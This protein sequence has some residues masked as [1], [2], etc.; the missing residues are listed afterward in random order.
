[1]AR[2]PCAEGPALIA[3]A[4]GTNPDTPDS[5]TWCSAGVAFAT[6]LPSRNFCHGKHLLSLWSGCACA[7]LGLKTSQQIEIAAAAE[8]RV[9]IKPFAIPK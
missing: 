5:G 9:T 3:G 4:N 7:S 6:Q 1:M 2:S 8:M